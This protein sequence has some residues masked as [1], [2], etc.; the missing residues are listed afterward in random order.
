MGHFIRFLSLSLLFWTTFFVPVFAQKVVIMSK[1]IVFLQPSSYYTLEDSSGKLVF[2]QLL[3]THWQNQFIVADKNVGFNYHRGSAYWLKIELQNETSEE[4][5]LL[6]FSDPHVKHLQVY[7]VQSNGSVKTFPPTGSGEAFGSRA[8]AHKNYVYSFHLAKG[9]KMTVY[10]RIGPS[11]WFSSIHPNVRSVTNFSDYFFSEYHLLGFYYGIILILIVYNFILGFFVHENVHFYYCAYLVC[12]GLYTYAED[13]LAIQWLWPNQPY[14]NILLLQLAPI[15]LLLSFLFYSDRFIDIERHYPAARIYIWLSALLYSTAYFVF[16]GYH[17]EIGFFYLLPF[18][19]TCFA[20]VKSYQQG[21][22]PARFFVMGNSMIILSLVVYYLRL[23]EWIP[24][25]VFTVYSFNYAFVFE[26]VVLSIALADKVKN[27]K[28]LSEEAQK[29]TIRQLQINDELQQKVNKELEGKV[30]ER[31]KELVGKTRELTEANQKLEQLKLQLYEMNSKMDINIWEL[32]KEVKKE[33]EA[34]ILNN[35]VS[36]E[37]FLSIFPDKKCYEYLKELKWK[38]G[39]VC[40]KCGNTKY[41][42]GNNQYTYKC[43]Q[44]QHQESVTSNTLFHALKF[45]ISKAFYLAYF[46]TRNT[47]R[48]TYEEIGAMLDLNKNTVWN[49]DKKLKESGK[50]KNGNGVPEWDKLLLA[51]S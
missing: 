5:W 14:F 38:D 19:I 41:G 12:C 29:E 34:R 40:P 16:F 22:R 45:P 43:T 20:A 33:T 6:E 9:G 42:K 13:G 15:L 1:E 39:F 26:A 48:L 4:S 8:I 27:T 32:K 25:N 2:T 28:I 47:N 44:C 31:T 35:V 10:A 30:Q 51:K 11:K 36:Y 18:L 21:Y 23:L 7:L 49:F 24:S 3:E 17:K 37:E 50:G 46:L